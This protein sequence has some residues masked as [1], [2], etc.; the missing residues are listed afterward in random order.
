LA[1]LLNKF[2]RLHKFSLIALLVLSMMS[3]LVGLSGFFLYF[4]TDVEKLIGHYP[5]FDQIENRYKLTKIKPDH[6]VESK[7]V[8]YYSRWAIIVS[9][10]WAFYDH[11]GFDFN[12]M[13]IALTESIK[14]RRLVR[15]ASTITQQVV[16]N[17]ILTPEKTLWRKF[18]ELILAYKLEKLL[19][20]DRILEIYL[21]L[22][23][24]GDGV[25]G[26]KQASQH[27]FNKHPQNLSVREGAFFGHA[28]TKS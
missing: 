5:Y 4:Q 22:V 25:Y 9:E 8:D 12:Q 2:V 11:Q 18:R 7:E 15:G 10:D 26:I 6:W 19:T 27:Y 23:E 3:L 28:I 20:K 21:N 17:A 16:K 14:Q 13:K 1:K 24:L